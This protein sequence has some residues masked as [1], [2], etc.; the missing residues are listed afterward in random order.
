MSFLHRLQ[1]CNQLR[2]HHHLKRFW[3]FATPTILATC[4]LLGITE[5]YAVGGA[6]AIALFAYGMEGVCE[7]ADL[8]TGPGNIDVAAAKRTLVEL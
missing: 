4:A 7:K 6:Q 5:V 8:V 3:W 2:L 1:R